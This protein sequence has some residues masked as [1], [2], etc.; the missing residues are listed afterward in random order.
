[1]S[2]CGLSR[3]LES[4]ASILGD[5]CAR[6]NNCQID[7]IVKLILATAKSEVAVLTM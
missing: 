7:L 1:M 3:R 6:L 4:L 2:T 5:S